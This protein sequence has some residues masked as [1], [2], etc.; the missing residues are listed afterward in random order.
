LLASGNIRRLKENILLVLPF[1]AIILLMLAIFPKNSY[2]FIHGLYQQ[3][4]FARA[5]G[6]SLVS[7][8]PVGFVKLLPFALIAL[9]AMH[10]RKYAGDL[11]ECLAFFTG[12]V[13]LMLIY[14]TLVFDYS[15]S[16]LFGFIPFIAYWSGLQT[17]GGQTGL[18]SAMKYIFFVFLLAASCSPV[19]MK[20]FKTEYVMYWVYGLV[21]AIFLFVPL[22]PLFQRGKTI[23]DSDHLI[24]NANS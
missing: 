19:M 3:E 6:T 2:Y 4:A 7:L 9:G 23:S 16:T 22:T 12:T 10:V 15:V 8:V 1:A 5:G 24:V 17:A 20:F 18:R 14:P 11:G 13:I 21:A